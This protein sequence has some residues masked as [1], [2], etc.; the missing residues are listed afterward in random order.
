MELV[1]VGSDGRF[2]IEAYGV[3]GLSVGGHLWTESILL[4]PYDVSAWS[5]NKVSDLTLDCFGKVF[6]SSPR[7]EIFL[8]GCGSEGSMVSKSLLYDLKN[9]GLVLESMNTGAACRTYNLLLSE[10]RR[11]A[12]GLMPINSL[13]N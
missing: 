6:S 11:V 10:D 4:L 5:V 7:V 3:E 2:Y 12:A 9:Q 13:G 8:L 1:Q